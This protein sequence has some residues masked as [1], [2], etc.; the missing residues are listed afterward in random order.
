MFDPIS[1]EIITEAAE[2]A[3]EAAAD[4]VA[5]AVEANA[6]IAQGAA[7]AGSTAEGTEALTIDSEELGELESIAAKGEEEVS[8]LGERYNGWCMKSVCQGE[9]SSFACSGAIDRAT[10]K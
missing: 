7:E 9:Y 8:S 6:E 10:R 4:A 5:E 1:A 3:V 2:E